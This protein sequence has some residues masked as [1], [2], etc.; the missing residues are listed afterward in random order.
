MVMV[1]SPG[2]PPASENRGPVSW[3]A[4]G[5]CAGG[6]A[7]GSAGATA[8]ANGVEAAGVAVSCVPCAAARA[9]LPGSA[10]IEGLVASDDDVGWPPLAADR[11]AW[12]AA[13]AAADPPVAAAPAVE[14][15]LT[16]AAEALAG[17][18]AAVAA[19]DAAAAE[20][21]AELAPL[22]VMAPA[23]LAAESLVDAEL[24]AAESLP[25][26]VEAI[27][28]VAAEPATAATAA[29]SA[30]ETL[31][32]VFAPVVRE[33]LP[34]A[35]A[36]VLACPATDFEKGAGDASEFPAVT[37]P[38]ADP[39]AVWRPAA[40]PAEP[41]AIACP[42]APA[43]ARDKV[44]CFLC[45]TP[46]AAAAAAAPEAMPWA[47]FELSEELALVPDPVREAMSL[48]DGVVNAAEM[49][50]AFAG[51]ELCTA[52]GP[53]AVPPPGVVPVVLEAPFPGFVPAA[54]AAEPAEAAALAAAPPSDIWTALPAAFSE[55]ESVR[56]L[57]AA[58]RS[59]CRRASSFRRAAVLLRCGRSSRRD[60]SSSRR[61]AVE[62]SLLSF[63]ESAAAF[64]AA[65][66]VASEPLSRP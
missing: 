3:L 24:V 10:W 50:A 29:P 2:L 40:A 9:T 42:A 58:L 37:L 57:A 63:A 13:N 26:V 60:A 1:C 46:A 6:E 11:A 53:F 25:A 45:P 52:A 12:T 20:M 35:E 39:R 51:V 64:R 32:M 5:I 30:R 62:A 27:A 41:D 21:P 4:S 18:V 49:T 61:L 59:G 28:V 16:T 34:A 19:E 54:C 7:A 22:T 44:V 33:G 66:K 14:L 55:V 47:A 23:P 65:P 48:G 38:A 17:A 15:G 56:S 43:V 31:G 36:R 8:A